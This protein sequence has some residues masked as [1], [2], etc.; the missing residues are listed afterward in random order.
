MSMM[1][2]TAH[3]SN[4]DQS[5]PKKAKYYSEDIVK[6]QELSDIEINFAQGLLKGYCQK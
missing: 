5:P 4:D 1:D 2:L 6:G 3:C